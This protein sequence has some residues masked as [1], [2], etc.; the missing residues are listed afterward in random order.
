MVG[1][2]VDVGV[3]DPSGWFMLDYV[4]G[5][6]APNGLKLAPRCLKIALCW[7]K[8]VLR[9]PKWLLKSSQVPQDEA[10]TTLRWLPN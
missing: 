8:L 1:V 3:S 5:M 2:G 9:R 4:G 6:L 10:K 7:F